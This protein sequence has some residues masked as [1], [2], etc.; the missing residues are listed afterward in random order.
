M[1]MH[2]D[3][4]KAFFIS[5]SL[6]F[7]FSPIAFIGANEIYPWYILMPLLFWT[8]YDHFILVIS[9][10]IGVALIAFLSLKIA[11]DFAQIV[12][13]FVFL[14][15]ACSYKNGYSFR[16]LVVKSNFCCSIQAMFCHRFAKLFQ[17]CNFFSK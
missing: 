15:G 11:L 16:C 10:F 17:F 6:I 7:Y 1:K 4:F 3:N 12:V 5:W 14:K 9:G 2:L 13:I 8:S